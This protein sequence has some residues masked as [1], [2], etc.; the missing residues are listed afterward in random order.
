MDPKWLATYKPLSDL[1]MTYGW[2]VA[3]YII[4]AEFAE[5][6]QTAEYIRNNPPQND[7]DRSVVENK[8]Y[9]A[10]CDAV[11]HPV[12]RAR[13]TWYGNKLNYFRNFNHLYES[14]IFSYYK[15][16]YAQS[17]LCLLS[18]L[19]GIMLAFY[20]YNIAVNTSKPSIPSLLGRIRATASPSRDADLTTAHDMYRDTLATFL[21]SW[22]YRNTAS[23]DFSLSVLNRHYVLHGM[24]AGNFYRPQDVH[25]L[26]LAFD[27][28]IEF[29]ALRQRVSDV[30]LPDVG[31]DAFLDARRCYYEALA[32]GVPTVSQSWSVERRLLL[33]HAFYVAPSHDPS[34][35]ESLAK[36]MSLLAELDIMMGK[37][38]SDADRK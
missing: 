16:E 22:I 25:R 13:A 29:F 8:I 7:Q 21:E 2:F 35:A 33:D 24:D 14:A 4:G 11:F 38:K 31:Q 9:N 12:N 6:E 26:V 37:A 36:T 27:L 30:F 18:A 34:L 32:A 1:F 5:V 19:E 3:P 15:R 10:L 23:S 28:I 17:V 20:G